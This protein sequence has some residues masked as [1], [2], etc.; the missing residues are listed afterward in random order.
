MGERLQITSAAIGRGQ[1][2]VS[3]DG[4]LVGFLRVG[5]CSDGMSETVPPYSVN[6][7][8]P[9]SYFSRFRCNV[10]VKSG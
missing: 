9:G 6:I 5:A 4:E 10:D 3:D 1:A 2:T 7:S 8:L